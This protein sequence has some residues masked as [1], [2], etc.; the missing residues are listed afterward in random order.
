[1]SEGGLVRIAETNLGDSA[2]S[3][4]GSSRYPRPT[5]LRCFLTGRRTLAER[6]RNDAAV[7]A[8]DEREPRHLARVEPRRDD[9]DDVRGVGDRLAVD[10]DDRI[11][12]DVDAESPER[13]G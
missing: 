2:E 10:R 9:P 13:L 6:H 1:M 3:W 11:A 7:P 5:L 12:A 8:V 4:A